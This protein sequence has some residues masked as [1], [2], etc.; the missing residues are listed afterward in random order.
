MLF[1]L[2]IYEAVPMN[3]DQF[4]VAAGGDKCIECRAIFLPAGEDR[5]GLHALGTIWNITTLVFTEFVYC[6]EY[7][8]TQGNLE[9][10]M[11]VQITG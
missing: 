8:N 1:P 2:V 3:R 9:K 6:D 5:T 10:N 11:D 4:P 7:I